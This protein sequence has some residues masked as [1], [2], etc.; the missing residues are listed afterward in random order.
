MNGGAHQQFGFLRSFR[1]C[2]D[3]GVQTR[4]TGEGAGLTEKA[5]RKL[6]ALRLELAEDQCE[7]ARGPC[8]ELGRN[9]E[10]GKRK[11][12]LRHNG[13]IHD[14]C[15]VKAARLSV[16]HPRSRRLH[17]VT[18]VACASL[19]HRDLLDSSSTLESARHARI[20]R[21]SECGWR[22]L[23]SHK[24]SAVSP[25][26]LVT[27]YAGC[28]LPSHSRISSLCS[29]RRGGGVYFPM[30]LRDSRTGLRT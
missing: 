17:D 16:S 25:V 28:I 14:R 7:S 15:G 8:H 27:A 1:S 12:H 23:C 29:P 9:L 2:G 22:R 26:R 21:S 10:F 6:P 24:S 18:P 30:P 13:F 20:G 19:V 11:T 5:H 4:E 3:V